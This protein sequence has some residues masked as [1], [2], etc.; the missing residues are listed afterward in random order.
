MRVTNETLWA[1]IEPLMTEERLTEAVELVPAKPTD[2]KVAEST[3]GEWLELVSGD[4]AAVLKFVGSSEKAV[5]VLGRVKT[6][7]AEL[8]GIGRFFTQNRVDYTPEEAQASNGVVYPQYA[9]RILL[10]VQQRFFLH[11]LKEA[12]DVPLADYMVA[13]L[14]AS[15]NAKYQ[16]NLQKIQSEKMKRR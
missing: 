10:E 2:R 15:A 1:D 6:L 13:W 3:V 16:R 11:S 5:D 14:D 8:E 7:K 12:E 4:D 9:A